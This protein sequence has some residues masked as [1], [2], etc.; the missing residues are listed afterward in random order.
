MH[1]VFGFISM[2]GRIGMDLK[3]SYSVG[4]IKN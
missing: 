2:I 4:E 1:I 3:K